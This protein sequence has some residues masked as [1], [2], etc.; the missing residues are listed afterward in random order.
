MTRINQNIF[1][2]AQF[3]IGLSLYGQWDVVNEGLEGYPGDLYFV[4]ENIGWFSGYN[5]LLKTT[6]GGD[7]W[8]IVPLTTYSDFSNFHFF[9]DSVIW[10]TASRKVLK[11]INGGLSWIPLYNLTDNKDFKKVSQVNDSVAYIGGVDYNNN[12][13][14]I[15]KSMDGGNQWQDMDNSSLLNQSGLDLLKFFSD[16]SGFAIGSSDTVLTIFRTNNRGDSWTLQ[17]TTEFSVISDV[18]TINDSVY[19]FTAIKYYDEYRDYL[20]GVTSDTFKTWTIKSQNQQPLASFYVLNDTSVYAVLQDSLSVDINKSIDGGSHWNNVKNIA[21]INPRMWFE[22][23]IFFPSANT[24][25]ASINSSFYI[26]Y[27][28]TDGGK[29]WHLISTNYP[30]RDIFFMDHN[31]G[32]LSGGLSV[33]GAHGPRFGNMFRTI[34]GGDTWESGLGL[35]AGIEKIRFFDKQRGALLTETAI[36]MTHNSGNNWTKRFENNFDSSGFT[37]RGRNGD[38][39]FI[40][41]HTVFAVGSA[42]WEGDSTGAVVLGS[43]D[44][45]A[46]WGLILKYPD[47]A[48]DNYHLNSIYTNGSVTWLVGINGLILKYIYPDSFTVINSHTDIPLRDV[49]FADTD[50][51]WISGGYINDQQSHT[52][53]LQTK[54]GGK[55]FREIPG[56]N[57]EINDMVFTDSLHGW[58]VGEDGTRHGVIIATSDGGETWIPQKQDLSAPLNTV[59]FLEGI[60]WAVGYNGLIL[61]TEDGVTWDENSADNIFPEFFRL[62]QNYPNPFNPS[63]TIE[64]SLLK[65]EFVQLKVY[66]LLGKEVSTLVSQK[67][68]QGNHTY[69]FN[70]KNLASGIYYYQLVAGTGSGQRFREVKKM[71]L[72]R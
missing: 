49:F 4:S 1:L 65:S 15:L 26:L 6:D 24:A 53:L 64:F 61:K 60:G 10:V 50:H 55:T 48:E 7:T 23:S 21:D 33:Y 32:F 36:Y 31:T 59:H 39:S 34:N 14:W 62:S 72:L 56:F 66:N 29:N 43:T 18:Q 46:N 58:A 45:G 41:E 69:T 67:L 38:I 71:I 20:F 22:C 27:R 17:K 37:F 28:S 5:T 68:H 57:Y 16:S 30:Y 63:T 9:G 25:F 13:I 35:N 3:I 2:Y 44:N 12:R 19:Y 42:V 8:N 54:D 52:M 70:G 47:T 51:G 40:N 11:S